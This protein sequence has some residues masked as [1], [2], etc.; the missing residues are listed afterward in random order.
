MTVRQLSK[1]FIENHLWT[2]PAIINSVTFWNWGRV[3]ETDDHVRADHSASGGI[4]LSRWALWT[5]E[6][7]NADKLASPDLAHWS[8]SLSYQHSGVLRM[9]LC[10]AISRQNLPWS[11]TSFETSIIS[12][13]FLSSGYVLGFI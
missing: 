10:S 4:S 5:G 3:G 6:V 11:V 1:H 9:E 8:T 13:H 2:L 7:S 12:S